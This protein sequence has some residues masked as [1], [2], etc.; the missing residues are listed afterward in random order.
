[1]NLALNHLSLPALDPTRLGDWYVEALGFTRH[2]KYL[3]GADGSLL[4]FTK[5][6]PL[7]R[8]D[9]HIGFR[10]DARDTL[11]VWQKRFQSAGL[12]TRFT[13]D[14]DHASL[15]LTDP[16]GNTIEIFDQPS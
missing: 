6:S 13:L 9:V 16:E 7:K 10:V 4:V 5:G 14:D 1:M 2:G 12:P 3:W 11:L 15:F 8:K